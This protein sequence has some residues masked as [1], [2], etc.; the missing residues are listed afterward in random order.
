L[1]FES[2]NVGAFAVPLAG[3]TPL[4]RH[5][6]GGMRSCRSRRTWHRSN[7]GFPRT[8]EVLIVSTV[9]SRR[10]TGLPT[11]GPALPARQRWERNRERHRGIAKRRQRA[12]R[13]GR[14]TSHTFIVPVNQG[15]SY[16]E[17]PGEGREVPVR[18]PR[19]RHSAGA[20]TLSPEST[21]PP[22]VARRMVSPCLDE[23]DA[24]NGHVRICGRPGRAIA[25]ADPASVDFQAEQIAAE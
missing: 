25:R 1:S 14:R 13:E 12:R 7:R 9:T 10:G 22:R 3:A 8:W 16:R 17:D 20:S 11:P 23:P 4:H 18:E 5:G 2:P 24:L 21:Q 6:N 19:R 15:Y